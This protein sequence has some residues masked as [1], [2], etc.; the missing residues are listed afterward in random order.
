MAGRKVF[1]SQTVDGRTGE[2]LSDTVVFVSKNNEI[3]G[4][5][6]KTEGL[7]WFYNLTGNEIKLM[8][9]FSELADE[10][11]VI[12][13]SKKRREDIMEILGIRS[14]RAFY[15]IIQQL[16]EKDMLIKMTVSDYV[17]NPATF[18]RCKSS[19]LPDM[20]AAYRELKKTYESN[21]VQP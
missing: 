21:K 7:A 13:M 14:D 3:F 2:L 6:R 20:I 12:V 4:M 16:A 18:F 1:H 15:Y 11:G 5:Y 9:T 17:V 19:K 8:V 10:N